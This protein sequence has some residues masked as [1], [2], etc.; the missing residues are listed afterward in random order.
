MIVYAL[1]HF[2]DYSFD[3]YFHLWNNGFPGKHFHC[4]RVVRQE[5]ALSPLSFVLVA[6]I[7]QY[8]VNK[9]L[10]I[11]IINLPLPQRGGPFPIIQYAD[12]TL[13]LMPA[14]SMTF[15]LS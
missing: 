8:V 1:K 7:L 2:I 12:D 11:G 4:K 9:A 5:D 14:N 6:G 15:A 13:L 10:D 3:V